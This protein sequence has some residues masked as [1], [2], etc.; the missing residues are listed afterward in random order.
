[1]DADVGAP[2][3]EEPL[4]ANVI[5]TDD[6]CL[7]HPM[8]TALND[9]GLLWLQRTGREVPEFWK[10]ELDATLGGGTRYDTWIALRGGQFLSVRQ[11]QLL[12]RVERFDLPALLA[13]V[14]RA[15]QR[16]HAL[17]H[18]GL[19]SSAENRIRRRMDGV[20]QGWA[21]DFYETLTLP[22]VALP[23]NRRYVDVA[24]ADTGICAIDKAQRHS[25]VWESVR[26]ALVQR[27]LRRD[28]RRGGPRLRP[29]CGRR[30][31]L[32]EAD[33]QSRARPRPGSIHRCRW[34]TTT[35]ARSRRPGRSPVGRRRLG[36]RRRRRRRMPPVSS[37]NS[38]RPEAAAPFGM[39]DTSSA[40]RRQTVRRATCA[41]ATTAAL[42]ST[43]TE[44]ETGGCGIADDGLAKC[45]TLLVDP[46]PVPTRERFRGCRTD[47]A[48]GAESPSVVA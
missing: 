5:V 31:Q 27:S 29:H 7:W 9:A 16:T 19:D 6:R 1:M 13:P 2:E 20:G 22:R 47:R 37:C 33:G 35:P 28:R 32:Q 3:A 25:F 42:S 10:E 15:A 43:S 23:A 48:D 26:W 12:E 24:P 17:L 21:G 14:R 18:H 30:R 38:H 8:T 11:F 39:M 36:R 41:C 40:G 34:L 4:T 45:W 44:S 46:T